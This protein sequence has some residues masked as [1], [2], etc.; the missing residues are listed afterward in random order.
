MSIYM[1]SYAHYD[2]CIARKG[3][4]TVIEVTY[5][6]GSLKHTEE[7]P[8]KGDKVWLRVTG[9]P[10]QY[11]LWY[12]ADGKDFR[13]AGTGDT[14]YLSSETHGNF[15]GI[16]LGLWAQSPAEKGW[17]EFDYFEYR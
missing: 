6:L 13:Q 5:R 14:R 15:T 2:I 10:M 3:G 8:F 11:K 9:D 17:A 16:M 1:D 7:F 12:S 4:K